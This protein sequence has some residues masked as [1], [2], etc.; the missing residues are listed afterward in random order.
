MWC[1]GR[2]SIVQGRLLG[3]FCAGPEKN[4]LKSE[5]DIY[6][7]QPGIELFM[8]TI[9]W[10]AFLILYFVELRYK[11]RIWRPNC[12]GYYS[13]L[14][15]KRNIGVLITRQGNLFI[16]WGK[17]LVPRG[18]LIFLLKIVSKLQPRKI[19]QENDRPDKWTGF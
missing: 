11:M 3:S 10:L 5:A 18:S 15:I 1:V 12:K 16:Q 7:S 9:D 19:F 4:T 17:G 14:E 2:Q 8:Q 13:F 6:F